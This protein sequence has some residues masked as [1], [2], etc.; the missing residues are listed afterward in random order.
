MGPSSSGSQATVASV[1]TSTLL[2]GLGISGGVISSL[3][4]SAGPTLTPQ[5]TQNPTPPSIPAKSSTEKAASP[6]PKTNTP[7]EEKQAAREDDEEENEE[8]GDGDQD[9]S[10]ADKKRKNK[11]APDN[12]EKQANSTVA[13]KSVVPTH[14]STAKE[15]EEGEPTAEGTTVLVTT[16]AEQLVRAEMNLTNVIVTSTQGPRNDSTELQIPQ[17]ATVSPKINGEGKERPFYVH[18]GE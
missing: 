3:P 2:A 12:D 16:E 13:N 14:A 17:S 9:E 11:T 1:V 6:D 15:K 7:S 10:E 4:S 18:T 5:T 8:D